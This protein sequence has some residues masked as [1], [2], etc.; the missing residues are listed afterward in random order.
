MPGAYKGP[1]FCEAAN[2]GWQL[3]MGEWTQCQMRATEMRSGL[4]VCKI[5]AKSASFY[6]YVTPEAERPSEKSWKSWKTEDGDI[7]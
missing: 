2:L 5:H 6:A 3:T 7:Q 4:R 1:D